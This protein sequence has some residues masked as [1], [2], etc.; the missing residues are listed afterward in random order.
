VALA[1]GEETQHALNPIRKVVTM[2]QGMQTKVSQEGAA[3]Q[4]LYNK[5]MCFCDTGGGDLAASI[6]AAEDK[7]PSVSSSIDAAVAKMTGCKSTLKQAQTD[8]SAAKSSMAA[9]TALRTKEAATFAAL[10]AD[11]DANT[12]AIAKAI[13]ALEK[14]LA[15]SFVQTPAA[16][17]LRHALS[18]ADLPESDSGAVMAFLSQGSD[19]A[20]QSGE[21]LGILKQMGDT[22]AQTLVD[23]ISTEDAS[24]RS[25][26]GLMSAKTKEVA[27]LTA[28]VET[29]TSQI[30]ELGVSIV[31]MKEDVQDTTTALAEDTH[32]LSNL[33]KSCGT[34][35]AEWQERS[36]T[37]AEEMVALADTIK[38]LNDDDALELFKKTLPSPSASLLQVQR[39]TSAVRQKALIA[40]RQAKQVGNSQD[41]VKLELL[42]MALAG[43]KSAGQGGFGKVI[44]MID[45]MVSL[46]HREQR[47]D[48]DQKEYCNSQ[49]DVAD[50]KKKALERHVA[51]DETQIESAKE[52]IATLIEEIAAL[53]TS[54]KA[55]DK[56]VAEA[57][58]QRKEENMEYKALVAS[59][60]ASKEVLIFARNRLNKFY[61]PKLYKPE[62]KVELSAEDRIVENEGGVVSTAAPSG[63]AGTGITV[64]TQ[65]LA[66]NRRD[67][68]APPPATWDAYAKKSSE[69]SGV[70]AMIRLLILDMEKELTEAGTN[71]KDSQVDYELMLREAASKRVTDSQALTTKSSAKAD[72]QAELE[73]HTERRAGDLRELMATTKYIMAMHGE[74][75]WLLQYFEVRK[76]ARVGEIDSLKKAKDVLAGADYSLLQVR[77]HGFLSR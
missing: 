17:V 65:V 64:L 6:G 10:K 21:I 13:A 25:Y 42:A 18:H 22:M 2:L 39:S 47:D 72:I 7:I 51:D 38:V 4:I 69:G 12:A 16:A 8:R 23:A 70:I 63:I 43:K 33:K 11:A 24:I 53:E 76:G 57:T 29:K 62:A 32:F 20:P 59:D 41:H 45:D 34:K 73:A 26:K 14:G 35:T 66:H 28:T 9:A 75:D 46:L 74:C 58:Q 54:I 37:R 19:Y 48:D 55:L 5:F 67:A 56:A 3:E 68:P 1:S 27:A 44:K 61:Q 15:G 77:A 49:F 50:D 31:M 60:T 40:L 30:G 36:K 71:E 52:S